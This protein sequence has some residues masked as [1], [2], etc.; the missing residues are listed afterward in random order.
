MLG[1]QDKSFTGEQSRKGLLWG[2]SQPL[3]DEGGGSTL[4]NQPSPSFCSSWGESHPGRKIPVGLPKLHFSPSPKC[5]PS[6]NKNKLF[7]IQN[8]PQAAAELGFQPENGCCENR[9]CDC[10]FMSFCSCFSLSEL[11][12]AGCPWLSPAVISAAAH[13]PKPF[14]LWWGDLAQATAF[15]T[16]DGLQII[17][18]KLFAKLPQGCCMSVAGALGTGAVGWPSGVGDGATVLQIQT[19]GFE[20]I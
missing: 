15:E 18:K 20:G 9:Y 14:G 2:C 11:V 19:P 8:V 5:A 12:S 7:L 1:K 13:T 16:A 3:T 10:F 4:A 6:K 17:C